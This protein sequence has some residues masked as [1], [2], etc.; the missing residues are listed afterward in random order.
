MDTRG[1]FEPN[2]SMTK[3]VKRFAVQAAVGLALAAGTL[4]AA[5]APKT[6][7]LWPNGAPGALGTADSDQPK[8]TI[9]L[10]DKPVGTVLIGW[11]RRG[12]YAQAELFHFA[13]DREAVR[14]QTVA[15]ALR[16]VQK[17]LTS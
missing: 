3:R 1:P 8:I 7:L 11:K 5:T 14:R 17:I 4:G 16:G 2:Y 15:A 13:G 9:Y 12:G 6:V 10:P